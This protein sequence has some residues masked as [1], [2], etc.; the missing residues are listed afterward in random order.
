[1]TKKTIGFYLSICACVLALVA[2]VLYG[3]AGQ[4]SGV[5]R[6]LLIVSIVLSVICLGLNLVRAGFPG[7]NL[8]PLINAV[9]L[10]AALALSIGPMVNTVVFAFMGMTPMSAAEGYLIF[11][12]VTLCAWCL[13]VIA[14]F[15]GM[16]R[17]A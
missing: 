8:L 2:C 13:S 14:S 17:K 5:V 12:G 15:T 3:S 11:A 6:P 9:L 10:M 4:L 7:S 1:M 16:I